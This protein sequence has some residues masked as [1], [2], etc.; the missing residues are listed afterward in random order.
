MNTIIETISWLE[1]K[2][3]KHIAVLVNGPINSVVPKGFK[4]V[5]LQADEGVMQQRNVFGR[6]PKVYLIKDCPVEVDAVVIADRVFFAAAMRRCE[7][8]LRHGVVVVPADSEVLVSSKYKGFD[9]Q[10]AAWETSAAAN[11]VARCNLKG[12][13]LEFGC[14]Y[15]RSFF[16]NYHGMKHWLAGHFYAFD[17][18][19]G[20]S[21]PDPLES[22]Y[23]GGDFALGSYCCNR[24]TFLLLSEMA[25][26]APDRLQTVEGFYEQ[27]LQVAAAEYGLAEKSVSVCVI[28]CDLLE[29][30]RQVLEFISPLLEDGAL[31]YFDDWRLTRA[32]SRVGERA[33]AL[34]W[35]AK[36]DRFELVEFDRTHW[37]HQWFIFGRRD[38]AVEQKS[39]QLTPAY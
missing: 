10:Q 28:D 34:E 2:G 6:E 20:L 8:L 16:N 1:S 24:E 19:A 15:G 30:T 11:Y 22:E 12:H 33:A 38:F 18:F 39:H 29:P 27:T 9:A 5:L 25:E 7:C 32:S 17:S 31:I 26:V 13:Y 4:G 37:Q 14:W 23:T 35:L 21:P 3:Y 36:N